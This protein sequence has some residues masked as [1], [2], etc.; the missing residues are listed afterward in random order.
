MPEKPLIA[1]VGGNGFIGFSLAK[2]LIKKFRIRILDV[3]SPSRRTNGRMEFVRCDIRNYEEVRSSLKGADLVIHAAIIQIPM[4]NEQKQLAYNVNFIGTHNVCD[5]VYTDRNIKGMILAGTWHTIGEK[6]LK[7]VIDE[8]FGFRPDKVESRA[9]LY[10]LSK[11]AQ[12]SIVRFYGEMSEK[13]FGIIRMGTVLGEG[14]PEET[15]ASIFIENGLKG[16]PITPYKHSMYRPMLYVDIED[17]CKAY[18]NFAMKILNEKHWQGRDSLSHVVN[19]YYPKLITILGLTEAIREAIRR[20]TDYKVNPEIKIVDKGLPMM[21]SKGDEKWIKA[22]V[23]KASRMLGLKNL[24]SPYES[25]E[26]IIKQR[27]ARSRK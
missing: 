4:I 19:V 7:G 15:A 26:K 23:S 14:M 11:I 25:V 6:E 3:K 18:E 21:F 12:E 16:K 17:V 20:L 5:V 10:V 27:L 1:I 8:E 13:I 22:D 2:H 24:R 9:R